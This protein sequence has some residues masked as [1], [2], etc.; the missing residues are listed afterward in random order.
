MQ[1]LKRVE[2]NKD[3]TSGIWEISD[4]LIVQTLEL[5]W[6]N[7]KQSISCIPTGAYKCKI[8]DTP[9]E[10]RTS[11][12][13]Y[14]HISIENVPKRSGIKIHIANFVSQLKGCIAPGETTVDFNND[15]K[16]DVTNSGKTLEKMIK[17]LPQ[18]FSLLIVNAYGNI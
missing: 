2:S 11:R 13:D 6:K 14:K 18:E 12:F 15:G 3:Y 9:E 4:D 1:I 5:P 17:E 8:L 16:L 7:N 10:L